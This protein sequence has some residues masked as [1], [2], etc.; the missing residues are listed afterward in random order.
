MIHRLIGAVLLMLLAACTSAPTPQV[1]AEVAGEP[2]TAAEFTARMADHRTEVASDFYDRHGA[3]PNQPGFWSAQ[4][5]STTPRAMLRQ[6]TLDALVEIKVQQVMARDAGLVDDIGYDAFL[7]QLEEENQSR[8]QRLDRQ[9]PIFGP[10]QYTEETYFSYT[11]DR[12]VL[13][14]TSALPATTDYTALVDER[15][16]QATVVVHDDV[17][18]AL[19]P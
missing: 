14:L 10:Q 13:D 17:M 11:F 7:R 3:D 19:L 2:V 9:E 1:V 16:R 18:E 4:Y 15:V 12:M 5:G 8:R 6:R